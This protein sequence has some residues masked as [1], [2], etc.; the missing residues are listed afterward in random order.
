MLLDF[1]TRVSGAWKKWPETQAT[2]RSVHQYEELA[3]GSRY[4]YERKLADL[5]FAYMDQ[6]QQHQYGSITVS[7]SSELYDAKEDDTFA[8]RVDPK[9]GDKY[10]STEA[11]EV[12]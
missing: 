5:T 3:G 9:Q 10:Y 6:Q 1:W 12:G 8:I 11:T 7:D 2:V 4:M